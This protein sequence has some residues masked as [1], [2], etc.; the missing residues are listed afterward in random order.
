M[1]TDLP[2][3]WWGGQSLGFHGSDIEAISLLCT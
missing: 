1:T 2:G 3:A